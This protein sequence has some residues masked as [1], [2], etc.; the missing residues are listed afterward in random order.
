MPWASKKQ[1]AWGNSKTGRKEM[2]VSK[3]DEFNKATKGKK[4]PE[5]VKAKKHS[6]K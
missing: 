6:K 5:K 1:M 3:V 2:G 4:L